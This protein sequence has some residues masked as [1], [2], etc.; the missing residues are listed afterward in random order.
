MIGGARP[1]APAADRPSP[2]GTALLE[3]P[4]MLATL[5]A[6]M[7]SGPTAEITSQTSFNRWQYELVLYS[8]VV[9]TFALFAAGLYSLATSKEVSKRYRTAAVASTCVCWVATLAYVALTL[10]W[11]L[12]YTSNAAGTLY[13]PDPGTTV[14]PLR[15]M[16]WSV[17]VP[18][19]VI[20]FLA[21]CTLARTSSVMTRFWAM[22]AAF[23]MILTG[24]FGVIGV[25]QATG[26][27]TLGYAVWGAVSTVFF[28]II[29]VVLYKPY[30]ATVA[31][32]TPTTAISLRNAVILLG[33]LFGVY[34]LLYLIP[35]WASDG[36]AG[37][38][39]V[40]QVGFTAADIAAKAGFGLLIHKIAK[41]RTAEDA[42]SEA[43]SVSDEYPAQVWI[44]SELVSLPVVGT[45][46][47]GDGELA[48]AAT[49]DGS[50]RAATTPRA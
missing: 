31:S 4:A 20:E 35:F 9:A 6:L 38:A 13:T 15:Y 32:V 19:L 21:V 11:L 37:W 8:F 40:T 44:S 45:A 43:S 30:R 47:D 7:V 36:D 29:Y 48:R 25:G 46:V 14:T 41:L 49:G 39:T 26:P 42:A 5:P 2:A 1:G 22:A 50:G 24:Y 18:I 28:V 27:S 12:Q 33:S 34:P 23:L 17:T 10:V 3:G 16:D